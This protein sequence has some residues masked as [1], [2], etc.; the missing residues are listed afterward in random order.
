M[1]KSFFIDLHCVMIH[2]T[3]TEQTN[4]EQLC[5]HPM[6]KIIQNLHYVY[7]IYREEKVLNHAH[8]FDIFHIKSLWVSVSVVVVFIFFKTLINF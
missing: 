5:F 7:N 2:D 4:K 3:R 6:M 8:T 1:Y